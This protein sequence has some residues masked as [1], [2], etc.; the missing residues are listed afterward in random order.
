[1]INTETI[2][3]ELL[4]EG[5]LA[6]VQ[7]LVAK[8]RSALKEV[9]PNIERMAVL[10][11]ELLHGSRGYVDG[12]QMAAFLAV[13]TGDQ[14]AW[15][16]VDEALGISGDPALGW[17]TF[18]KGLEVLGTSFDQR[19]WFHLIENAANKG[20]LPARMSVAKAHG[21]KLPII[22]QLYLLG[23][24]LRGIAAFCWLSSRN[25]KDMRLPLSTRTTE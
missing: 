5:D 24:G 21:P 16:Y 10:K 1:M 14:R 23:C 25:P 8:A 12:L 2:K 19:A 22:R 4:T 3:R 18:H 7:E 11:S 17:L 20:F 6:A 9:P 13:L 15:R